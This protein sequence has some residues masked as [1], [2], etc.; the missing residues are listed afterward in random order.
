M[1]CCATLSDRQRCGSTSGWAP[2]DQIERY[3]DSAET[4]LETSSSLYRG[5]RSAEEDD[6]EYDEAEDDEV[7]EGSYVGEDDDAN[8]EAGLRNSVAEASYNPQQQL[9]PLYSKGGSGDS[10]EI[11]LQHPLQQ[12]AIDSATADDSGAASNN[13]AGRGGNSLQHPL[14][15]SLTDGGAADS[16]PVEHTEAGTQEEALRNHGPAPSMGLGRTSPS[17]VQ[18]RSSSPS[19]QLRRPSPSAASSNQ[20]RR[21]SPSPSVGLGR[22]SPAKR[23]AQTKMT[24]NPSS[25]SLVMDAL[26][27]Q[28]TRPGA[29]RLGKVDSAAVSSAHSELAEQ[30]WQ[31]RDGGKHHHSPRKAHKPHLQQLSAQETNQEKWQQWG[32]QLSMGDP[33]AADTLSDSR[34][35]PSGDCARRSHPSHVAHENR[36]SHS[37]K[38]DSDIRSDSGGASRRS[39]VSSSWHWPRRHSLD[40]RTDHDKQGSQQQPWSGARSLDAWSD[41]SRTASQQ[42]PWSSNRNLAAAPR[43]VT[44]YQAQ[45]CDYVILSRGLTLPS[46]KCSELVCSRAAPCWY[47]TCAARSIN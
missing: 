10:E 42:L 23:V 30:Q 39:H 47:T 20:L 8:G 5:S 32:R 43:S 33:R 13:T 22:Q 15:Q 9:G 24:S 2:S 41:T 12:T 26:A 14:Q 40:V 7:Y 16:S 38:G 37:S 29:P 28:Q 44:R 1:V 45:Q 17:K 11:V 6:D 18:G 34:G 21:P 19:N 27:A 35:H 25:G 36:M 31:Q 3:I 4:L 46:C